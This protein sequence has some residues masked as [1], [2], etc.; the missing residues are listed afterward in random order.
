MDQ[1]NALSPTGV[2]GV[3]VVGLESLIYSLGS[4]IPRFGLQKEVQRSPSDSDAWLLSHPGPLTAGV[5]GVKL[6]LV[7]WLSSAPQKKLGPQIPCAGDKTREHRAR[8]YS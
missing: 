1:D 6:A 3:S 4:P 5:D 7:S 2:R 8:G